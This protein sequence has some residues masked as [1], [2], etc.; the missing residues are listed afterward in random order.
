MTSVVDDMSCRASVLSNQEMSTHI[1]EG[2]DGHYMLAFSHPLSH[3]TYDITQTHM[4][5]VGY[6]GYQETLSATSNAEALS[7]VLVERGLI[8]RAHLKLCRDKDE[9]TTEAIKSAFRARASRVGDNGVFIFAYH[10]PTT[11]H[12]STPCLLSSNYKENCTATHITAATLLGWMEELGPKLPRWILLFLDCEL[13]SQLAKPLTAPQAVAGI[14]KCCVFCSN[15]PSTP[16]QLT[17]ASL[18]H[19]IFTFFAVWAI[20]QCTPS[21]GPDQDLPVQRLLRVSDISDKI[22]ECCKAVISLCVPETQ[23]KAAEPTVM[24]VRV[25][26]FIPLQR[27]TVER[28]GAGEDMPD[29]AGEGE[30][31]TVRLTLARFSFVEKFY[32][33]RRKKQRVRLCSMGEEWLQYMR[34]GDT[35]PLHILNRHGF[36]ANKDML[37]ALLRLLVYS[38]ALIQD[39]SVQNSTAEP[40]TLIM[41]YVQAAGVVEHVAASTEIGACP[42]QFQQVYEAY[43]LALQHKNIKSSEVHKLAQNV[44]KDK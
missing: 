23:S 27:F 10:G 22:K 15:T 36:L 34:H 28:G 29:G 12:E 7:G 8:Q 9:S 41:L 38:L 14:E 18:Q 21:P 11:V 33:R 32:Q 31:T 42:D 5:S 16:S 13:A 17:T 19:S 30:D 39:S 26:P 6:R 40:N 37:T 43:C 25:Q 3:L 4:L 24:S 2:S 44:K 1:F 20:R 35:S